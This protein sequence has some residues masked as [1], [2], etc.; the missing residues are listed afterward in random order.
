M[1]ASKTPISNVEGYINYFR[2]LASMHT[3]L[4][5]EEDSE[6]GDGVPGTIHFTRIG[7]EEVLSALQ[8]GMGWPCLTL[9]LYEIDAAGQTIADIKLQPKGAFM[10]LDNPYSGSNR[11]QEAC[12]SNSEKLLSIF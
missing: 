8:S 3:D 10:I 1:N 11:D 4:R 5:H 7:V 2:F 9:E 12:F 6:G